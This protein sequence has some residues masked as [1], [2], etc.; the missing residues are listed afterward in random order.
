MRNSFFLIATIFAISFTACKKGIDDVP[1][2][3]PAPPPTTSVSQADLL[4]DSV[5]LYSKEVYL[6]NDI[7]PPYQQFNPRQYSGATEFE[8]AS[9]VMNGIRKLQPLDRFSF[10]TTRESSA[11]LQSGA[12]VDFGFFIKAASIDKT[13]PIDSVFWFVS[14][15]Y[16]KSTAGTAGVQRG[17]Y[18]SKINNTT[19]TYSQSSASILNDVFFGNTT[20]ASFEFVKPDGSRVTSNLSKSSFISN[21]VLHKSV[22]ATGGKKVGYL[23]FNQFF[24]GPSRTELNTAF[25]YFQSE[26]I[27]E[28]V[29][30][31]R[32]NPGGSTET[33]DDFANLIAPASANNQVMYKYIFNNNLQQGNFPLLKRKPGFQNVSFSPDINMERFQ[34]SGNVNLSRV[35]FIVTRSSASASELLINNLRP[36]M[37]VKLIGDTTYGKPVGFFPIDIFN[38]SIYPI[39]FKTVNSAGNAD[40]YKGFA[41]DKLSPDGVNK[42]WGD[43]TEPSL[44]SALKYITTGNFR[45][46]A[47]S[48]I[49]LARQ[50]RMQK[51]Y[52]PLTKTLEDNKFSGMFIEKQRR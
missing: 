20:S 41:P 36:Y 40:F 52:E 21:S 48:D 19:L 33:Q 39:S 16:D 50:M 23:V 27:N 10:V 7:I 31:L 37:D 43:V 26:G 4:K 15:V 12:D 47:N 38:Y 35:F 9:N 13:D 51:Q 29:V 46:S 30:D 28:L 45:I 22:I 14:Y 11:G 2:T 3:P 24:G 6:W 42:N 32:Y 25:S 18:I 44:A 1:V 8:A 49:E 34:K 17:W 5:Y